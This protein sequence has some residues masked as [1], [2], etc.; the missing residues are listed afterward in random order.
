[1][2]D[3]SFDLEVQKYACTFN[4]DCTASTRAS[5]AKLSRPRYR[6]SPSARRSHV[7]ANSFAFRAIVVDCRDQPPRTILEGSNSWRACTKSGVSTAKLGR[8]RVRRSLD[9]LYQ[10]TREKVNR[11]CVWEGH[12]RGTPNRKRWDEILL[13]QVNDEIVGWHEN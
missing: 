6:T 1:M 13:D 4:V 9:D 7:K 8:A 10:R 2:S 12:F 3:R 5:R 11:K